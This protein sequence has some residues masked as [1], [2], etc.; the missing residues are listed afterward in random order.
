MLLDKTLESPLDC[1]QIK[2]VN[3][4]GNQSWIFI[5]RTDAEAEA[6]VLLPSDVKNWFIG[7]D[8]DARKDWRRKEKEMTENEM[9]VWLHWSKE[10]KFE[11]VP[12][13]SEG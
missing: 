4:N 11:Q 2:P 6:P 9:V 3:P 10:H 8:P 13:D 1:K 5:G 7:K 12:G